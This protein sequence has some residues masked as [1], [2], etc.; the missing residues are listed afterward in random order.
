MATFINFLNMKSLM[1][2]L[3]L[4]EIFLLKK[5]ALFQMISIFYLIIHLNNV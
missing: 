4:M 1:F 3:K 5:C 2:N